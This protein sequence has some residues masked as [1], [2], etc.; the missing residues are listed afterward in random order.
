MTYNKIELTEKFY[1][2]ATGDDMGIYNLGSAYKTEEEAI[3]A[4]SKQI[5]NRENGITVL[6]AITHI[7]AKDLPITVN[8]MSIE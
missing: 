2:L 7:T 8:T 4:A 1:M 3:K 6:K 5:L